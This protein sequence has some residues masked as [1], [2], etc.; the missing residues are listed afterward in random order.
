[1]KNAV[2]KL[3]DIFVLNDKNC[4]S[5]SNFLVININ[6]CSSCSVKHFNASL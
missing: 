4:H 2:S 6:S 1:M 5:L 3:C